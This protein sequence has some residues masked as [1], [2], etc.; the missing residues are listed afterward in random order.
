MRKPNQEIDKFGNK[1]IQIIVIFATTTNTTTIELFNIASKKRKG[2]S[3]F[4]PLYM[5]QWQRCSAS[6]AEPQQVQSMPVN[7]SAKCI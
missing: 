2:M 7:A 1:K 3:E 5:F 6:S 4:G